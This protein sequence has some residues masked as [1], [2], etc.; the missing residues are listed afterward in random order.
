M[1]IS[2]TK[3]ILIT[4]SNGFVGKALYDE[5]IKRNY[6]LRG[7]VRSLS[8]FVKNQSNVVVGQLND[9]TDWRK[10]LKGCAVVVHLAA[11]VHILDNE[12]TI[13]ESDF[14]MENAK[15]TIN[16]AKQ[17][18]GMGVKRFIFIS[19]IGVNGSKTGKT[20]ITANSEI[21][22]QT[23]YTRSKLAAEIGL[24]KIASNSNMEVVII[25]CP[26]IYGK[27][28]PGNFALLEKFIDMGIPL[29]FASIKNQRS[30][31]YLSNLTDFI[32]VCI[33][34]QKVAGKLFVI[35]D[36]I[37]LS[38][39]DIVKVIAGLS[40]K[41]ARVFKFPLNILFQLFRVLG[42]EKMQE[43]LMENFQIDSSETFAI[44]N[45]SPRFDP[46]KFLDYI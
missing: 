12:K 45:W 32:A 31:I 35:D 46:R 19:S 21:D 11:K 16:L 9:E 34:H 6:V 41:R 39:S 7:T 18:V 13:S 36:N 23:P 43:S 8:K 15:A 4:G 30:L 17:A 2:S 24:N 40:G 29:P 42:K 22:P 25:R 37:S 20:P 10:A 1:S 5:L 38:T 33:E 28:A 14:M 26:A 44:T 27:G 3:K